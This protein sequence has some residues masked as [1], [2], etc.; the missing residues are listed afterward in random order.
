MII[1]SSQCW[2]LVRA[3][4]NNGDVNLEEFYLW[5]EAEMEK[6]LVKLDVQLKMT[7][8]EKD[9]SARAETMAESKIFEVKQKAKMDVDEA[10]W[11][12]ERTA[13]FG[14][15][16]IEMIHDSSDGS[17]LLAELGGMKISALQK[18]AEEIGVDKEE[19]DD[20]EEKSEIVALIAQKVEAEN[21]A[22]KVSQHV[23]A[24]AKFADAIAVGAE[25]IGLQ[26]ASA[27]AAAV[28]GGASNLDTGAEEGKVAKAHARANKKANKLANTTKAEVSMQT[29]TCAYCG[30][31][32]SQVACV[33][34]WAS[35]GNVYCSQY[36]H[37]EAS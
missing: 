32:F 26:A 31:H 28:A 21:G 14:L 35:Y 9:A 20:A 37:D 29:M 16:E 1:S 11:T 25:A 5:Y 27:V 18:R 36:C 13:L 2:Y 8:F 24:M 22:G 33:E 4:D 17:A 10:L 7:L 12:V 34:S 30:E 19:L 3:G 23:G 6:Q 15:D